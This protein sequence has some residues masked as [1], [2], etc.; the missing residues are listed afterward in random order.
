[1]EVSGKLHAPASL[2]QGRS[3]WY[4]LNRRVGGLQSRSGRG[5]EK[6]PAQ[7]LLSKYFIEHFLLNVALQTK[8]QLKKLLQISQSMGKPTILVKITFIFPAE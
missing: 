8:G 6:F 4:P 7:T 5:G 3:P 2:P 1:M